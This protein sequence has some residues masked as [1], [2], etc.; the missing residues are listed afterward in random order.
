VSEVAT[1]AARKLATKAMEA[2][3]E[4]VDDLEARGLSRYAYVEIV[5]L[6]SRVQ[7]VD[8]FEFGVG[9]PVRPLPTP[10]P[11]EPTGEVNPDAKMFDA[12]VP[13]TEPP[14]APVA[15]SA[16]PNEHAALHDIHGVFFITAEEI[17]DFG[18]TKDLIRPQM[19]IIAS[20]TSMVN[21]CFY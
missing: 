6:A 15:L 19:E 9:R 17:F 11:G 14:E 2:R 5:G 13:T 20:R 8:R 10:I 16:I 12:W 1:E 21:D 3:K 4:W 18:L 7:A